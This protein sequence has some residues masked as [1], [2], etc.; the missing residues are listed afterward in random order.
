MEQP[1]LSAQF[2]YLEQKLQE[3]NT[4][5]ARLQQRVESQEY[6]MQEQGHRIA[7]LEG[8]LT[9]ANAQLARATHLDDKLAQQKDELLQLVERRTSRPASAS[10][11]A[12]A[13]TR[14]PWSSPAR[15]SSA[16]G[17]TTTAI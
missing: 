16:T 14:T 3:A 4:A 5:I 9:Q 6:A 17:S 1:H 12:T 13:R 8:E 15:P 2:D 11:S 10:S 7:Q